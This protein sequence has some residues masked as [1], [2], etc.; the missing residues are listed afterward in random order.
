MT[1]AALLLETQSQRQK[2][3]IQK[4]INARAE[5]PEEA[6]Y[7]LNSDGSAAWG[8][9]FAE[10]GAHGVSDIEIYFELD[11]CIELWSDLSAR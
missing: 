10:D 2:I 1:L 5:P 3:T 8:A 7:T 4:P 9:P 6:L 11:L